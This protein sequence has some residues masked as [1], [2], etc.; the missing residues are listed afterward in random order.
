MNLA[1]K[2][3]DTMSVATSIR[4]W[5]LSLNKFKSG[6]TFLFVEI[7]FRESSAC[8][9]PACLKACLVKLCNVHM[10]LVKINLSMSRYKVDKKKIDEITQQIYLT[11]RR[12]TP[13]ILQSNI[14]SRDSFVVGAF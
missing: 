12:L 13:F 7:E 1:A 10:F 9:A 5:V 6:V 8:G 4:V 11:M 14:E 2:V 3:I